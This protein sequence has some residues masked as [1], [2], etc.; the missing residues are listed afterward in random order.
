MRF[1]GYLRLAVVVIF[2]ATVVAAA[3]NKPEGKPGGFQV[4][5][6]AAKSC[7]A[8][9]S[10]RATAARAGSLQWVMGYVTAYGVDRAYQVAAT[11][12][13]SGALR[14]TNPEE[15]AKIIDQ[16]CDERHPD[17]DLWRAADDLI[18]QLGGTR[19]TP[20]PPVREYR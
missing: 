11:G 16:Y 12:D 4:Y 19:P 8:W 18:R 20:P 14:R 10:E 17:S 2:L 7:R 6:A 15:I 9:V 1:A 13:V 3:Q 5:G